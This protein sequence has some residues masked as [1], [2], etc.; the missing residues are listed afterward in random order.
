MVTIRLARFGRKK[1]AFYRVVVVD[2][3]KKVSG[4]SLGILGFWDPTKDN[5]KIDTDEVSRLVKTGAQLSA[6][7]KKLMSKTATP[8]NS[9][10]KS[11]LKTESTKQS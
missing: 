5:F 6:T 4:A 7:V 2:S 9:P 10:K 11:S 1:R 3:T 8:K